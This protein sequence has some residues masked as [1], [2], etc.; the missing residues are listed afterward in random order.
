ML[1]QRLRVAMAGDKMHKLGGLLAAESPDDLYRRLISHWQDPQQLVIGGHEPATWAQRE[2][3]KASLA[4]FAERMMLA[5]Q[6]G[7]LPDDILAKVDRAAMGVSLETRIPFL[8]REVVEFSW[9]VP[10]AMKIRD[11]QG[12]W[13]LRQVLHRYVPRAL[14]ERPKMGFSIPLDAWLRGPLREWAESL[15]DEAK[16]RREGYLD[17]A[18]IRH[19]WDEHL[20]GRRNWQYRLW[21]VLMFEAWL[22][23]EAAGGQ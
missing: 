2:T 3:D 19:C 4:G 14:F 12:K 6:L 23:D 18:P 10:L 8:D 21:N 13:L 1:P 11:G 17:P 16:L 5:D 15:L 9:R 20:S 7:Y 22:A